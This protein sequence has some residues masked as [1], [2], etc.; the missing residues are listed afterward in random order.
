MYGIFGIL[1]FD[2]KTRMNEQSA[3]RVCAVADWDVLSHVLVCRLLP[4]RKLSSLDWY[5]LHSCSSRQILDKSP[6]CPARDMELVLNLARHLQLSLKPVSMDAKAWA[7]EELKHMPV[8]EVNCKAAA[9]ADENV[10][11]TLRLRAVQ[12]M[13]LITCLQLLETQPQC[14]CSRCIWTKETVAELDVKP[15]LV[16]SLLV[17]HGKVCDQ[18]GVAHHSAKKLDNCMQADVAKRCLCLH[19]QGAGNMGR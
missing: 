6:F 5:T 17:S 1:T 2:V 9:Q 16:E 15:E 11:W 14:P 3:G 19:I 18:L 7:I 4:T 12:T 13:D 8:S 10:Y